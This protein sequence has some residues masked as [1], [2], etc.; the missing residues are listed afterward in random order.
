MAAL[1]ARHLLRP[2]FL[3]DQP[4]RQPLLNSL[5]AHHLLR[6]SFLSEQP[7][8]QPLLNSLAAR[9]L[10]RPSFLPDQPVRQAVLSIAAARHRLLPSFLLFSALLL[11]VSCGAPPV[12]KPHGYFRIDLPEKAYHPTAPGYPYR[13]EI[14]RY[15]LMSRDSSPSAEPWWANIQFPDH[16]AEIHLSYKPVH[17]NL[18]I[19]TEESRRMAYDHSVKASAIEE[20]NY[21]NPEKRVFG[22][23]YYIKGNAA[24]PFQFYLTDSTRHFLRGSLYIRATPNIDSLKP[25]IDFL[26]ADAIQLIET[27]EWAR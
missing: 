17:G 18:G 4:V 20:E 19:Y 9:H 2:S 5:A 21:I 11:M 10:L 13:F 23:I 8:H 7:V 27:L 22:T 25:V 14:P 1:A 26:E 24:S 15:A 6:P 3:P 12:P 16:K